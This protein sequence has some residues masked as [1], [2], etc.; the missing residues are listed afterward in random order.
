VK[1]VILGIVIGLITGVT[2]TWI[3]SRHH[4][5]EEHAEEHNEE[6]R[7][8]H[9]TNG[10]L[11]IKVDKAT[12]ER[13]GLKAA[14]LEPAQLPP[15]V[16]GYG[17]VVDPAPLSTLP[18]EQLSAQ[19]SLE[20]SSKEYQRLK[21]LYAQDQNVSTRAVEAAEVAM[22]KDQILVEAAKARLALTLG[23]VALTQSNLQEFVGSLISL[24][25]ALV[26][27]DIPLGEALPS[28]PTG[29]RI[30]RVGAEDHP[31]PAEF[32]GPAPT[33]DPQT[34]SQG[35]LFLLKAD[36]LAPGTAV[37]GWL[38][39]PGEAQH[40]IIVPRAALLRHEG[41]VFVYVQTDEETF[42]RKEVEAER[43]VEN[44]LFVRSG[45]A[46]NDKVV[47]AGAQQLLSEELKAAS[48]GE[49]E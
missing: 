37:T 8:Y 24:K 31:I 28:L 20:A 18:V 44:G 41:E 45:F 16:K 2:V 27:I 29:G 36:S 42:Q 15:E 25:T 35:F 12:Q 19:A 3:F 30:A 11:L 6:S 40:G 49:E 47:I 22:K 17:R 23:Q 7:V 13:I 34:Q 10:E 43:P 4:E 1:K 32:L 33:A 21:G 38:Q 48:G 39:I 14:P 5:K 9:G 26:R 46:P